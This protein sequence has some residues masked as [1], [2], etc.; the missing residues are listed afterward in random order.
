M[1]ENKMNSPHPED[2]GSM[3]HHEQE[4]GK[5]KENHCDCGDN[6]CCL[7]H[8]RVKKCVWALLFFL[9]G[10]AFAQLWSCCCQSYHGKYHN[11]IEH[12]AKMKHMSYPNEIGGGIIIINTEGLPDVD[13]FTGRYHPN[14]AKKSAKG[15]QKKLNINE[16]NNGTQPTADVNNNE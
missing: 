11:I 4:A 1:E 6:D 16:P 9:A 2:R 7:H 14:M 10:F 3:R 13:H 12:S 15:Y 8:C 5:H